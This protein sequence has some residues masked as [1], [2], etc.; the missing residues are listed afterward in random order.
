MT[1]SGL[2]EEV[3]R[4]TPHISKK[5]TEVV[6]NTIFDSMI[7]A[8]KSDERIEIRGFGSFSLHYRAPRIGRN[9]KTGESVGLAGKYVPHFKPGKELRDSSGTLLG[10]GGD[11]VEMETDSPD[12]ATARAAEAVLRDAGGTRCV[13]YI[14]GKPSQKKATKKKVYKTREMTAE[15]EAEV[16]EAERVQHR[17]HARRGA[18]R[19]MRQQGG[20]ARPAG[21][22]ARLHLARTVCRRAERHVSELI[23]SDDG[24]VNAEVLRYLNRLSDLLFVLARVANDKGSADVLWV[25]GGGRDDDDAGA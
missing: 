5:D 2:I 6:V 10:S 7:E 3:A 18:L 1:K 11:I 24:E 13:Q 23:A 12:R 15:V 17:G 25:P 21:A 4:L 22:A 9:P 14:G 20:A 19:V 16:A 8:L